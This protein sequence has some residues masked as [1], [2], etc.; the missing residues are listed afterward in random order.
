MADNPQTTPEP[1]L[2]PGCGRRCI[3]C[4][5][6]LGADRSNSSRYCDRL[7][8]GAFKR[9]FTDRAKERER[10]RDLLEA[11]LEAAAL[12][13]IADEDLNLLLAV[14]RELRLTW[15]DR[16]RSRPA[17]A[18]P[19]RDFLAEFDALGSAPERPNLQAV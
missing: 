15:A 6:P 4:Q 14:H 11:H 12:R 5:K 7:C 3:W 9:A 19:E 10:V 1:E 2:H 13:A 17:P 8:A 16:D 18:V